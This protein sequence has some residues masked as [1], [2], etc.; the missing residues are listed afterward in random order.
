EEVERELLR[1]NLSGDRLC[2]LVFVGA[3]PTQNEIQELIDQLIV[4]K[5]TFPVT[6]SGANSGE[7]VA[8]ARP[9]VEE[10]KIAP[11]PDAQNGSPASNVASVP[12]FITKTQKIR[13]RELGYDDEKI[14][15]MRPAEAH[16]ILGISS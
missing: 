2:K 15:Q 4:G 10:P 16:K 9:V 1:F 5:R 14:A 6:A 12:F 8:P 13:L 11:N 7:Q 3:R